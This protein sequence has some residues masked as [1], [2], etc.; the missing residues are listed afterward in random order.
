MELMAEATT[1]HAKQAC[2]LCLNPSP[3][4]DM[5][6]VIEGE[7]FLALCPGCLTEGMNAAMRHLPSDPVVMENARL[8]DELDAAR[9]LTEAAE[10]VVSVL[11]GAW[12]RM[13]SRARKEKEAAASE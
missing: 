1:G 2:Y 12:K 5:G 13:Q 9:E 3:V 8:R 7:G 10:N 11:F 4:V 6:V